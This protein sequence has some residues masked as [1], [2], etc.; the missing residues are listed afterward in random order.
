M[1]ANTLFQFAEGYP[2]QN[3][4]KKWIAQSA[5]LLQ[6]ITGI[7]GIGQLSKG[8]SLD[9][10]SSDVE[11][12]TEWT[13]GTPVDLKNL[14]TQTP[15]FGILSLSGKLTFIL[16]GS[17]S[18]LTG[19]SVD[20]RDLK[21]IVPYLKLN[22]QARLDFTTKEPQ[23][24][25][26]PVYI[27]TP[28]PT[29]GDSISITG[30]GLIDKLQAG[31]TVKRLVFSHDSSDSFII[32]SAELTGRLEI[33]ESDIIG[34]E[35]DVALTYKREDPKA[36]NGSTITLA[37]AEIKGGVL[38]NL[39]TGTLLATDVTLIES[40]KSLNPSTNWQLSK[41]TVTGSLAG[42]FGNLLTATS[43]VKATYQLRNTAPEVKDQ[44]TITLESASLALNDPIQG[45]LKQ[46]LGNSASLEAR[47][48]LIRQVSNTNGS[49]SVWQ[50]VQFD[51]IA[52]LTLAPDPAFSVEGQ[53][54]IAWR[55]SDSTWNNAETLTLKSAKLN[56]ASGITNQ[57]NKYFNAEI[58]VSDLVFSKASG[59]ESAN[60]QAEQFK[61]KSSLK[62]LPNG[63]TQSTDAE[64]SWYRR[65]PAPELNKRETFILNK[66]II[67]LGGETKTE[68][69]APLLNGRASI[70]VSD[71]VIAP[72][73]LSEQSSTWEVNS[74]K[75]KATAD[76]ATKFAGLNIAADAS[77]MY[78]RYDSR[79][80]SETLIISQANLESA[81]GFASAGASVN[82]IVLSRASGETENSG[83]QLQ[84]FSIKA[85]SSL[86]LPGLSL[87]TDVTDLAWKR[88]DP[89][90]DNQQ[91][92]T[93]LNATLNSTLGRNLLEANAEAQNVVLIKDKNGIWM[94]QDW[95]AIG[96][97]NLNSNDFT[98]TGTV[99]L[100]YQKFNPD[101]K[102]ETFTLSEAILKSNLRPELTGGLIEGS[103]NL[104]IS[105]LVIAGSQETGG[106]WSAL[107]WKANAKLDLKSNITKGIT[108]DG[109]V[110]LAY[111]LNTT[112]GP[113]EP[114]ATVTLS[115]ANIDANISGGAIQTNL[116]VNNLV[117]GINQ[118]V[119][120]LDKPIVQNG[121]EYEYQ[122]RDGTP[123]LFKEAATSWQY[124]PIAWDASGDIN[125]RVDKLSL[126]GSANISYQKSNVNFNNQETYSISSA[127]INLSGSQIDFFTTK[128][129]SAPPSISASNIIV[130]RNTN[131]WAVESFEATANLS[132]D[133][134]GF[135]A[136][137]LANIAYS[138]TNSKY[139]NSETF[140]IKTA[141]INGKIATGE[142]LGISNT[143]ALS[144]SNVVLKRNLAADTW[145]VLSYELSGYTQLQTA[146][147]AANGS[148][149]I[150]YQASDSQSGTP[151]QFRINQASLT[152]DS[153]T[154]LGAVMDTTSATIGVTDVVL[155]RQSGQG[156]YELQQVTAEGK[157]KF[158]DS[159]ATP[160][161]ID[162][163]AKLTWRKQDPN[164][165][166]RESITI[167]S[168]VL[169]AGGGFDGIVEA[170]TDLKARDV[171]IVR[172]KENTGWQ[173]VQFEAE[174][175]TTIDVD[176]KRL[177]ADANGLV[178]YKRMD[179]ENENKESFTLVSAAI[180]GNLNAGN[181]S[182]LAISGSAAAQNL[183]ITRSSSNEP[184]ITKQFT[185]RGNL[186]LTAGTIK[187]AAD[188][189]FEYQLA[190]PNVLVDQKPATTHQV[191]DTQISIDLG[192][193]KEQKVTANDLFFVN[194]TLKDISASVNLD[195][196]YSLSN[197]KI[198]VETD[199][200]NQTTDDT[201]KLYFIASGTYESYSAKAVLPV[202]FKN[203]TI[204]SILGFDAYY[205]DEVSG[206]EGNFSISET[207][208][209]MDYS[210]FGPLSRFK[211]FFDKHTYSDNGTLLKPADLTQSADEPFV[212]TSE[213]G[214]FLLNL[215]A[216]DNSGKLLYDSNYDG[217]VNYLD[218]LL[219]G[220][221][222]SAVKEPI[223]GLPT[224]DLGLLV[225]KPGGGLNPITTLKY[226]SLLRPSTF[227]EWTPESITSTFAQRLENIPT[228][229]VDDDYSAYR[230]LTTASTQKEQKEAANAIEF[231]YQYTYLALI[232]KSILDKLGL[233]YAEPVL[234]WGRDPSL[235]ALDPNGS[236]QSSIIAYSALGNAILSRFGVNNTN[237]INPSDI[238]GRQALEPRFDPREQSHIYALLTEIL[239]QYPLQVVLD[240]L[241]QDWK[242]F[243]AN[244][245]SPANRIA[246]SGVETEANKQLH[247]A[248]ESS[249][250][251]FLTSVSHEVADDL[252]LL[253]DQ[254][255]TA[256]TVADHI[257]T[258]GNE[259]A[260]PAIAGLKRTLY[261]G[262]A[263][264]V[265]AKGLDNNNK[266]FNPTGE[267]LVSHAPSLL[268]IDDPNRNYDRYIRCLTPYL[269]K[270]GD[271][272]VARFGFELI[273]ADQKRILPPSHGL[274]LR[275]QFGGSAQRGRDYTLP[276]AQKHN[277]FFL[278]PG[279]YTHYIDIP[280]A[281]NSLLGLANV[282]DSAT[283]LQALSLQLKILGAHSGFTA[284]P[285]RSVAN[286]PLSI[287]YIQST[288]N[289]QAPEGNVDSSINFINTSIV[290]PTLVDN[291]WVHRASPN[292]SNNIMRAKNDGIPNIFVLANAPNDLP[293]IE[294]FNLE[295]Q[296][297]VVLADKTEANDLAVFAG[298][299]V[300]RD[301]GE[302]F[303][304]INGSSEQQTLPAIGAM[305]NVAGSVLATAT[306]GER[307]DVRIKSLNEELTNITLPLGKKLKATFDPSFDQ[308]FASTYD[309]YEL[310]AMSTS[311]NSNT[312]SRV[313]TYNLIAQIGSQYGDPVN[314]DRNT[315]R[316]FELPS[317][318]Q[319]QV[320]Q[321]QLRG[322]KTDDIYQLE[323]IK[324]IQ[325]NSFGLYLGHDRIAELE[326]TDKTAESQISFPVLTQWQPLNH[327]LDARD[328]LTGLDL[329]TLTAPKSDR[330]R[331]IQLDMDIYRESALENNLGFVF[332]SRTTGSVLDALTGGIVAT[333]ESEN[334]LQAVSEKAVFSAKGD[335]SK[336]ISANHRFIIG[337]N[338]DLGD[339]ILTPFI[340]VPGAT[341]FIATTSRFA[342]GGSNQTKWID[343]RTISFEDTRNF[344]NDYDDA[345][346]HVNQLAVVSDI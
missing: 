43:T 75:A 69:I 329:A 308:K 154:G 258:I 271:N 248:I 262:L 340:V 213:T 297:R 124:L 16:R 133:S 245:F 116:Q 184:W 252:Q 265:I 150:S 36:N 34:L 181:A 302:V 130:A 53:A 331:L 198:A 180:N 167:N 197:V 336:M 99:R 83:W 311:I 74:F 260:I 96:N 97:I 50:A 22:G 119:N 114:Q 39:F 307:G 153:Q 118:F 158:G 237:N 221:P 259:I 328:F 203:G 206:R 52:T 322:S 57:W 68:S 324:D 137:G 214:S 325:G 227:T 218:G 132:L 31:G 240:K 306:P 61:A 92:L 27:F 189:T 41:A 335:N 185:A 4:N 219:V 337:G 280:V 56:P 179:P 284:D 342:N 193:L 85:D 228:S 186:S 145:D 138:R 282:D 127:A 11:S 140:T 217:I 37:E 334:Y 243:D 188:G 112:G 316:I 42:N 294:G 110:A 291:H 310:L 301:T 341:G 234:L 165:E 343:G 283:H 159:T 32:N 312:P 292:T 204:G 270:S 58:E 88:A 162:A 215:N 266:Q 149:A 170:N 122:K 191:K 24:I 175:K 120:K 144:A 111:K 84:E 281:T 82:N 309:A 48:L 236:D 253:H 64:I 55:R 78:Q 317:H 285:A 19:W 201:D 212:T 47:N 94:P 263:D 287:Q 318:W 295:R 38:K 290:T 106:S 161:S 35:S 289:L 256:Q 199:D 115:R 102:R 205:K 71:L 344:D 279:F 60:W 136:T 81:F 51:A 333:I 28:G 314:F 113:G 63:I 21:L 257:P 321:F 195:K 332:V 146:G 298:L 251:I 160:L 242:D 77:L 210:E 126:N 174:T 272:Y 223:T 183:V 142:T 9:N 176:N 104:S 296:D 233:I 330:Q 275:L 190:N 327:D 66:A 125:L 268:F 93:V 261:S 273:D 320:V 80:Q 117:L 313:E 172:N 305:F 121:I 91:T 208:G 134:S 315:E 3:S 241:S 319:D 101:Y 269:A 304:M 90:H 141:S 224:S 147:I 226:I 200:F 152:L 293:I 135:A 100:I 178:R 29:P 105:D 40:D 143:A 286:L 45:E 76:L 20:A 73:T 79:Y 157:L 23:Y 168:A 182:T 67:S 129:A 345:I 44:T 346:I 177:L 70:E 2:K 169:K 235:P 123:T 231:N 255:T 155:T 264:R 187:I 98:S 229:F 148:V 239:A 33:T 59:S 216:V 156:Q 274:L 288:D 30:I 244:K 12:F 339:A 338:L 238:Y 163:N 246:R 323:V 303:A 249:F 62:I 17:G 8:L 131:Q 196:F 326:V 171:V 95:T 164:Q 107:S 6:P 276:E 108:I 173:I 54:E 25:G 103:T 207:S 14:T 166:N 139:A 65:N 250:R 7:G 277:T 72:V 247:A 86:I 46:L 128:E 89:R 5:T 15:S 49:S 232:T 13:S 10:L 222:D 194:G 1:A 109:D 299:V 192:N 151:E 87:N 220:L 254:F 267:G 300:Q 202:E 278:R 26:K 225:G 211:I 209:E 18:N 230:A